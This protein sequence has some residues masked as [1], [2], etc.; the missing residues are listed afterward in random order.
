M[1]LQS[2]PT[3]DDTDPYYKGIDLTKAGDI[4]TAPIIYPAD[5]VPESYRPLL[6]INPLTFIVEQVRAVMLWGE[7]PNW[8]G[9]AVYLAAGGLAAWLGFAWFMKTRKGFANVL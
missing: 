3:G 6:Y 9:M 8:V 4:Y 1:W 2:F 5:A 7:L